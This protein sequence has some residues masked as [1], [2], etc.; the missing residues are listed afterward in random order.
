MK[1]Q[2]HNKGELKEITVKLEKDVVEAFEKME[3]NSGISFADLIVTAMKRFRS[4]HGDYEHRLP[5]S[6]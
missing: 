5:L 3:V 6:E 4:V 2:V 1:S